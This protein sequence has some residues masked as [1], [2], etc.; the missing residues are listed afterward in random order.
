[1]NDAHIKNAAALLGRV[2]ISLIFI[3][4]GAHKIAAYSTTA[5]YMEKMGVPGLLLPLVIVTEL[6]GGLMILVGYQTRL[7]AFLMAGFTLLA[8]LLFH[9]DGWRC[10]EHDPF[11]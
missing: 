1:M 9:F 2:L 6:G 5:G 3:M 4:G 7:I 8:G 11:L 10:A